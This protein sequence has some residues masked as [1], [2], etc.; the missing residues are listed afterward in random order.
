MRR[1]NEVYVLFRTV[2][3]FDFL[4]SIRRKAYKSVWL[5]RE[6]SRVYLQTEDSKHALEPYR[7]C[8]SKRIPTGI[9]PEVDIIDL[10]CKYIRKLTTSGRQKAPNAASRVEIILNYDTGE[11]CLVRLDRCS[12]RVSPWDVILEG[13]FR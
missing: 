9:H 4:E 7:V 3:L 11:L 6:G 1:S 5:V 8:N 13:D 10:C 12:E 2:L